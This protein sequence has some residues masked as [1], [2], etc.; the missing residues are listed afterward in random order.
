[1]AERE[2]LGDGDERLSEW[3]DALMEDRERHAFE[4]ELEDDP[5]LREEL[6]QFEQTLEVLRRMPSQR[7][8]ADFLA[9]VQSRIRRR[10]RGRFYAALTKARF[11]YEAAFNI[12]LIAILLALYMTS[13]GKSDGE[14]RP[15][16]PEVFGLESRDAEIAQGILSNYGEPTQLA[17]REDSLLFELVV[18][19]EALQRFRGDLSLYP[20]TRIVGDP[21]EEGGGKFAVKVELPR[22]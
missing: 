19:A 14:L 13:M 2:T 8:P 12:L 16:R 5:A 10:T 21:R 18:D 22:R 4:A 11:P 15:V 17:V 3:V 6:E 7:A 9:G 1:M 20:D